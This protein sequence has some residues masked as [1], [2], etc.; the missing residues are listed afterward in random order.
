MSNPNDDPTMEALCNDIL[1]T[2]FANFEGGF[3]VPANPDLFK[4]LMAGWEER[5]AELKK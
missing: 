2:L 4:I 1:N 3:L 5:L